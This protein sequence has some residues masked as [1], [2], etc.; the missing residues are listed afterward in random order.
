MSRAPMARNERGI[1]L[2]TVLLVAFAVS[3]IALAGAMWTLNAALIT[4]SSDRTSIL[5]DVA[6]AGLEEGRS[7]LNSTPAVYPT[8]GYTTLA[9]NAPVTDASGATVP[10]VY[11]S[12]YVGPDGITSGQYGVFGTIISAVRDDYGNQVVRRLQINQ[13]SF[14][15]FSYF[16]NTEGN[17]VFANNDQIRGP[18]HSNDM[19][20]I[21]SSGATFFDQVTTAANTIQGEQYATFPG[22]AP[23][24]SVAPIPMPT[25]AA[26]PSLQVHAANA[27]MS[28]VSNTNGNTPG[29]ASMRIEFVAVDLNGDLDSTDANEGFVR[30]YQDNL[31]P[32]Y[33]TASLTG[34]P[35][36]AG[37][38]R[39]SPNCGAAIALPAIPNTGG[40]FR[41]AADTNAAGARNAQATS[42]LQSGTRRCYLGGDPRLTAL[43]WPAVVAADWN[44]VVGTWPLNGRGWIPRPGNIG[45]PTGVAAFANRP[46]NQYL[47]PINRDYNPA[48]EG[49][50]YVAGRVALSGVVNGRVTIASPNTIII[51][52]DF[53]TAIDPGSAAAADCAIIAGIFSGQDILVANNTIN[54]PQQIGGVNP[55]RTYDETTQEDIHSVLLTLNIFGAESYDTGPTAGEP[56]NGNNSG[57]GCLNLS[58]GVIQNTRGAVGLVDGHGY[59][60]RYS[61]NA[62]AQFDPPPYFPT[63]GR[64]VRNRIYELDPKGFDVAA[65]FAANQ[66]N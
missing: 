65:W 33:V 32:W 35:G 64:F 61:Y 17:I 8:T 29:E 53:R 51:A 40:H 55:Y 15:K 60:K 10:R 37:D 18:V 19:I 57:R 20:K 39:R 12:L 28:F 52:D 48:W 56:C 47:W 21:N 49:V 6:V 46:D 22:P 41:T 27:G 23:K 54:A 11:R 36:P 31:R 1:A 5:H 45:A 24:K 13:E 38:I 14:A 63:T 25:T 34:N 42:L 66:N 59:I 50:I 3:G 7:Q 16:T 26:F 58:G 44:A 2:I 9:S 4:K 30:I 43:N 62:C